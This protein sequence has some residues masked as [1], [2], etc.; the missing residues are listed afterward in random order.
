MHDTRARRTD[1]LCI[2]AIAVEWIFFGSCHF[3]FRAATE[4]E[5]PNWIL[6]FTHLGPAF[7]VGAIGMIEVTTGILVLL[8]KTRKWAALISLVLLFLFLP[9]IYHMLVSDTAFPGSTEAWRDFVR[10]LL[11]PN[12]VFLAL[13]AINLWYSPASL[14]IE[15]PQ[16]LE[17][18]LGQRR[19]AARGDATLVVAS[20]M[21]FANLAG[22]LAIS[23]TTGTH[24]VAYL[25]GMMCLATGALVGFLFGIPKINPEAARPADLRPNSNIEVVSDWLTKI[26]VGVGLVEFQKIGEFIARISRELGQSLAPQTGAESFARALIIYFFVAGIIQGYLLTRMYV[27][28]QFQDNK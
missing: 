10:V 8:P 16:V 28:R 14:T 7:I 4:A 1:N 13:C 17:A 6:S 27:G 5:I 23:K 20:V 25:W 21:L 12:H 19:G 3:T 11:V 15:T 22:F 9:S 2:L 24:S 26:I 18:I